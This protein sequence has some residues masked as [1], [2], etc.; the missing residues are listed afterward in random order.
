MDNEYL[1][2]LTPREGQRLHHVALTLTNLLHFDRLYPPGH[3]VS[4]AGCGAGDQ[5]TPRQNTA[6]ALDSF[7]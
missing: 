5:K 2:G 6:P 7:R 3:K 4:E 1:H